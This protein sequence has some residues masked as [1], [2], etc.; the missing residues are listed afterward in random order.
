MEQDVVDEVFGRR[1]R[2]R[3]VEPEHDRTGK[4]RRR[5]QAELRALVGEPK[6]R[7]LRPEEAARMRL[8]GQRRRR[9][10]ERQG[11]RARG[12]DHGAVA[13]MHTVEIADGDDSAVELAHRR[14]AVD[15]G[16]GFRRLEAL[17]H[18]ARGF[19]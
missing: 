8:E 18:R 5:E 3:R 14:C 9:P 6:E 11:A 16:E 1:F 2:Q 7:L 13:A 15:H 10:A 4:P 12:R 19:P 17:G